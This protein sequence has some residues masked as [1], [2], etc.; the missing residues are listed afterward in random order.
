MISPR[1]AACVAIGL[2]C[3]LWSAGPAACAEAPPAEHGAA[4]HDD[5]AAH[6][7][8][9][10]LSFD[11]D[12]A[13]WTL[14][15]FVLLLLILRKFAWGPIVAGLDKREK[16]IADDIAAAQQAHEDAKALLASYEAKLSSVQ[17]EVRAIIDEAKKDA[18]HTHG[19]ILAKA[20]SEAEAE[21][22]RATREISTA[23]DQALKEL[24]ETSANLAVELAGKVIRSKITPAEHSKLISE[25]LAN[26]PHNN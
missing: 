26:V 24:L 6:A 25:A 5:H 9:N 13:L 8:T 20:K 19:E 1:F 15:V 16:K 17:D 10:P 22:H 2:S 21:M 3:F 14:G 4:A 7:N 11:P 12:L 23:K 18:Q